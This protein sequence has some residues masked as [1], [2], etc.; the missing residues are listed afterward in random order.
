MQFYPRRIALA[1]VLEL[2][3]VFDAEIIHAGVTVGLVL[4][5]ITLPNATQKDAT[6]TS[7]PL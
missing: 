4:I 2:L 3:P 6:L 1:V 5:P 7:H